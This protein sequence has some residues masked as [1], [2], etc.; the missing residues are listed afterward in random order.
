MV[1][2]VTAVMATYICL[3]TSRHNKQ[4]QL[5]YGIKP[6]GFILT[7][8]G[9]VPWDQSYVSPVHRYGTDPKY[10]MLIPMGPVPCLAYAYEW[11]QSHV[12]LV[13]MHGT[14]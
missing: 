4:S 10:D 13:L 14:F 7:C 9:K 6:I 2:G 3:Q 1:F 12:Q 5:L 8:M 11:D